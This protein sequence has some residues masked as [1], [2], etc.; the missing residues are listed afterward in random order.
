MNLPIK[1]QEIVFIITSEIKNIV[2]K[3]STKTKVSLIIIVL[4]SRRGPI[5]MPII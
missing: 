1:N 3:S 4:A 5:Q 2:D